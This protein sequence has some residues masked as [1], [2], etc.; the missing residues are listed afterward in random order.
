MQGHNQHRKSSMTQ[1]IMRNRGGMVGT[2]E[3]RAQSNKN[4][5]PLHHINLQQQPLSESF[6]PHVDFNLRPIRAYKCRFNSRQQH[7]ETQAVGGKAHVEGLSGWKV[8]CLC[9]GFPVAAVCIGDVM[10][11]CSDLIV[12]YHQML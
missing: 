2:F 8:Q 9:P 6:N 11:S 3:I 4:D 1:T 5:V 12:K 10:F 7:N